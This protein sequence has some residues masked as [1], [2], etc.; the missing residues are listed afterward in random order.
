MS[1]KMKAIIGITLS[2]VF[3]IVLFATKGGCASR[4]AE[5]NVCAAQEKVAQTEVVAQAEAPAN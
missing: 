1:T 2:F 5:K 4:C 3:L